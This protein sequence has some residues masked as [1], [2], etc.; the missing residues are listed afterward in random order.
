MAV[1]FGGVRQ[2]APPTLS[3]SASSHAGFASGSHSG[4]ANFQDKLKVVF[5]A[6]VVPPLPR[7][8]HSGFSHEN[9][10]LLDLSSSGA[11]RSAQPARAAKHEQTQFNAGKKS[12][13]QRQTVRLCRLT[14]PSGQIS[15]PQQSDSYFN[16]MEPS[17]VSR[18]AE[19]CR[20]LAGF[21]T[22]TQETRPT[23]RPSAAKDGRTPAHHHLARP[24]GSKHSGSFDT[25]SRCPVAPGC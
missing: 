18:D 17:F 15:L 5:L 24:L 3:P 9:V 7:H 4:T 23:C 1:P 19:A 14:T 16:V 25:S 11:W 20:P 8:T 2:M 6:R 12:I 22:M 21:P 10:G 13:D